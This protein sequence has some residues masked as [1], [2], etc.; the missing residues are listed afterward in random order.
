MYEAAETWDESETNNTEDLRLEVDYGRYE[1]AMQN[2]GT[3][4]SSIRF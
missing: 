2:S 3:Y 4:C 1:H